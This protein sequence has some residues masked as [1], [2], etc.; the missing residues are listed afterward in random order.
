MPY[1]VAGRKPTS[2]PFLLLNHQ[3][4]GSAMKQIDL[5][6]DPYGFGDAH[7]Y[8]SGEFRSDNAQRWQFWDQI[9]VQMRLK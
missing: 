7:K 9:L 5:R 6:S 1:L 3:P 2:Q 8:H 4:S